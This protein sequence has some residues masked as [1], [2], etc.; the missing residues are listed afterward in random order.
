M[1]VWADTRLA[2]NFW[3]KVARDPDTGCWNWNA[4]LVKTSGYG[5]YR[6]P[7]PAQ[8]T[9][10]VLPHRLAYDVLVSSIPDGLTIDH[11]CRNR[12]CCNP[13]HLEVTTL[14]ENIRR[15]YEHRP[16]STLPTHCLRGHEYTSENTRTWLRANGQASRTCREC[17]A[18]YRARRKAA[19]ALPTA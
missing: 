16:P 13:D 3:S 1:S 10:S 8:S 12:L 11:L 19:A 17:E 2:S 4:A 18:D 6:G 5:Q 15:A 7:R 9:R 14:R